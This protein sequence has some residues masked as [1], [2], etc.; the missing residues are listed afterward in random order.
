MAWSVP[1]GTPLTYLRRLA[2]PYAE[3]YLAKPCTVLM[4]GKAMHRMVALVTK[5]SARNLSI[6]VLLG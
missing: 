6:S 4:P 5:T 3:L 2:K 1:F